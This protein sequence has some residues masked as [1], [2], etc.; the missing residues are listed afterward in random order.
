MRSNESRL[1]KLGLAKGA[2]ARITLTF[3]S[4]VIYMVLSVLT[5]Q[6]VSSVDAVWPSYGSERNAMASAVSNILYGAPLATVYSGLYDDFIQPT[7]SIDDML[8]RAKNRKIELNNLIPYSPSGLGAGQSI[9]VTFA[10]RV[11]G[12]HA[13]S[14]LWAFLSLMIVTVFAFVLRFSDNRALVVVAGLSALILMFASE[15]GAATVYASSQFP[16]SGY[17]YFSL[18]AAIPGMHI[19]LELISNE[20]TVSERQ[21]IFRRLLLFVQLVMFAIVL[22]INIAAIY[23][24]GP[25]A[26]AA[27]YALYQASRDRAARKGQLHKVI[28]IVCLLGATLVASRVAAPQAYR[29]AGRNGDMFWHRFIISLGANPH[30]PFGNLAEEYKGCYPEQPEKTLQPGILD[31]N[32]GCFWSEYTERHHMSRSE[33]NDHVFDK[34]FNAAIKDVFLRIAREYPIETFLT[35]IYYKPLVLADTLRSLFAFSDR[36]PGWAA[37]LVS[38]QLLILFSFALVA[39]QSSSRMG[40]VCFSLALGAI[41]T[42]GLYI[43][44]WSNPATTG[45]LF[46]YLLALLA[47]GLTA[48]LIV[49]SKLLVPPLRAPVPA[50]G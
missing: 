41:S 19:F 5:D 17:R 48:L 33:F 10:M 43:A 44:A 46:F 31:F 35:F 7:T 16:V 30:W 39:A 26:F 11:F 13:S 36:M 18:L 23:L 22:Y 14:M 45:D 15:L 37:L 3:L 28:V 2:G 20:K 34:E 21:T 38:A 32:G 12:I 9:F 40:V 8:E 42:C 47:T 49:V 25:F 6:K 50:A 4:L 24:Y 1:G 27:V 29:D